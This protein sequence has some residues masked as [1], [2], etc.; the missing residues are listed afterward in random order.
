[1]AFNDVGSKTIGKGQI[2]ASE[3]KREANIWICEIY[4]LYLQREIILVLT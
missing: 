1:M 2:K 3:R 4:C